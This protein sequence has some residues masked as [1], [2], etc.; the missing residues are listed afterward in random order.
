MVVEI[1]ALACELPATQHC[2]LSRWSSGELARCACQSGLV[3]SLSGST[4]W[5]WLHEDAIRP[6]QH[7][8]WVLPRDP[9]FATKAGRLLDLYERVWQGQPLQADE[10]VLSTGEKT[11]IQARRR[12]HATRPPRPGPALEVE[13]EYERCGAWA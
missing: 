3:A 11:S 8:G 9:A 1:K 4:V 5:R 13:H 7:H 2:P 6:G 12:K 10:F